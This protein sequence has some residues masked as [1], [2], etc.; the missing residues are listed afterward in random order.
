[1]IR[2]SALSLSL[3]AACTS[4]E[5]E[6]EFVAT[7][8]SPV[9]WESWSHA[10]VRSAHHE[11][12]VRRTIRTPTWCRELD[13]SSVLTGSDLVLRVAATEDEGPCPPGEG[14]WGYM[15]VVRNLRSGRYNLRVVHTDAAGGKR[16]EVVLRHQVLVE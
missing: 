1:M 6:V 5:P 3:L 15:A 12:T 4:A 2:I 11:I 16:P 7:P 10:G 14:L 8:L 13:A 9:E